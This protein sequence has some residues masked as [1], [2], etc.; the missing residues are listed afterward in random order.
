LA[1]GI[2][3]GKI[4]ADRLAVAIDQAVRDGDPAGHGDRAEAKQDQAVAAGARSRQP[5]AGS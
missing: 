4:G 5:I 1:G 3:V 2:D